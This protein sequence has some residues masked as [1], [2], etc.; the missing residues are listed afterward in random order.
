[1]SE[2][3]KIP[4]YMGDGPRRFHVMIKPT[5]ST[6]NLDCK[7]CYYL[8]K[9]PLVGSKGRIDDA[10]LEAFIK[11]YI[12]ENDGEEVVFS[13]Q[14]GEPTLL[15][16]DYF[17]KVLEIQKHYAKPGQT[18]EN[19]L[20]TNGT[21]LTDEWCE[22]LSAHRFLVGLSIDGPQDLHDH[23]RITKGGTPTHAKVMEAARLLH[24]HKTPFNTLTVLHRENARHPQRVYRFLRDE[25]GSTRMQF[26]PIVEHVDFATVAPGNWAP[27]RMPRIGEPQARPGRPGA[28]VT[29]W[30]V[31]PI[32]FGDFMNGVFD[33]WYA[34]DVGRTFIYLFESA[35]AQWMGGPAGI[36]VFAPICGK[37]VV[38][39]RDGAV[40]SCDHYVYPTHR[41]GNVA[42]QSLT[43]QIFSPRQYA[44]GIN[45]K[46]ALPRQCRSC[47]HLH[48]CNGECP[49]NRF[50]RSADGEPGLN[51]LC[52]GLMKYFDHISPHL[53]DMAKRF[54]QGKP[55]K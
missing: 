7:Y 48:L 37:N 33:E 11:A 50:I 44:F 54:R 27:E 41:I 49:K 39:E 17:R 10:L 32:D 18:I 36:C 28:V 24:K 4:D 22:F 42:E 9:E 52:S 51:Y 45:K 55:V 30:S 29:D 43:E 6:C 35:L 5:G 14:G 31:D 16:L 53:D 21:N 19:D 46:T 8:S 12:D 3:Y 1:M 34:K 20:Q 13:W 23:F 15:G 47:K 40:Y 25:V 2:P 26:I 38:L